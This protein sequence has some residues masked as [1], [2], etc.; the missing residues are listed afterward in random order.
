MVCKKTLSTSSSE[1]PQS[2]LAMSRHS[3][4][5][6]ASLHEKPYRIPAQL[7]LLFLHER[8]TT[9]NISNVNLVESNSKWY[10]TKLQHHY[11]GSKIEMNYWSENQFL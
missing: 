11:N 3:L 4:Q 7:C 8:G 9:S 6:Q 2:S 5:K 10:L 1:N